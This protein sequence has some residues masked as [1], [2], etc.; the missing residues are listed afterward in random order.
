MTDTTKTNETA[1]RMLTHPD[2]SLVPDV[3]DAQ[4][5]LLA[6]VARPDVA[7]WCRIALGTDSADDRAESLF[8]RNPPASPSERLTHRAECAAI[9]AALAEGWTCV[10]VT[11]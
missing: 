11:K 5:R 4:L 8:R 10:T 1:P 2:G 7:S 6:S 9:I 3:T